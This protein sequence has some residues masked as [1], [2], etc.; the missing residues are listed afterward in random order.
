MAV[1]LACM[2][3]PEWDV[4]VVGAGFGGLASALVLASAG[5]RTLVIEQHDEVGGKAAQ[6]HPGGIAVDCGPTVLT[7]RSVFDEL[8][9]IA[10][11]QLAEHVV[12][13]EHALLCRHAWSDG[14]RLDLYADID[15][16]AAEI[17]TLS[18]PR[19]AEGYRRFCRYAAAL[20]ER[21]DPTFMRAPN[22]GIVALGRRVGMS[23]LLGL[24]KVDWQRTM[25][26]AL[27]D[28]FTDPRL[29]QLFARYATYYGSSPF[30]APATMN[31]IAEVERRGVW[32]VQ[33]GM[34]ELA[35]AM[36][37]A[38]ERKHGRVLL[39]S[40]VAELRCTGGRV[41][42]VVLADGEVVRTQAV[43]WN[44][45]PA[46]LTSGALGDGVRRAVARESA[47]RSLSAMTWA[48]VGRV[49]G[50]PLA[51][52]NVF[53]GDDYAGEFDALFDAGRPPDDPTVYVC[54]LDR[55]HDTPSDRERLFLLTNAPA[56]PE[57]GDEREPPCRERMQRRLQSCGLA[58][59]IEAI[60]HGTPQHF[61]SRFPGSHGALYGSATHGAM[62]PWKRHRAQTKLPNL[63]MVGG[64]IHPG[65]G[66][67]MVAIGGM[68]AAR[69]LMA[70][71][72]RSSTVA[73]AGGTSTG[74]RR[75]SAAPS[76]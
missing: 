71:L 9:A 10:G 40:T 30:A 3:T 59:A 57:L 32:S 31:L 45:E 42:A 19:D 43:V 62:A 15:R 39:R 74:S 63:W 18:G 58:I 60:E 1:R 37:R 4:V 27:C 47:P 46:A 5:L 38:I 61:A 2:G 50:F 41:D 17:A 26:T 51:Y 22:E 8:F 28:A 67:P 23:G 11:E 52:H 44:G 76:R 49:S 7:M 69:Q 65:A 12:L 53:F 6:L 25:W 48:I 70:S 73:T 14:G 24:S 21:L 36:A 64:A 55:E 13:R 34:V 35:R 20:L 16:T 68:I 29:R 72:P 66:V 75:S 56:D 33:G 54:A